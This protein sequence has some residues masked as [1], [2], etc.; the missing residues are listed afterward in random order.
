M[1]LAS[2]NLGHQLRRPE[3]GT[4]EGWLETIVTWLQL[5]LGRCRGRAQAR[6]GGFSSHPARRLRIS[7]SALAF[8]LVERLRR[9]QFALPVPE[10]DL[11]EEIVPEAPHGVQGDEREAAVVRE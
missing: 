3:G 9:E 1:K 11:E 4:C 2:T 7:L 6:Q 8:L 10:L 5:L